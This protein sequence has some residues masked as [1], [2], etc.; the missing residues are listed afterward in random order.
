MESKIKEFRSE[1]NKIC[2]CGLC[3]TVTEMLICFAKLDSEVKLKNKTT[4]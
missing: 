2:D 4:R 1:A 3:R